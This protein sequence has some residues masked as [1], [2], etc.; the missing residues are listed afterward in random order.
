M[1]SLDLAAEPL[2]QLFDRLLAAYGPQHWW[3]ADS[4]FEVMLGAVL[5]QNTAW[6][7]VEKAMAALSE[8]GLLDLGALLQADSVEIAQCIR[9]AG[10]FNLKT[11]R[12]LALCR[13]LRDEGGEGALRQW[14][15]S[16]LR[17]ALLAVHGVGPETAD[18]ILLYAFRRPVFV[19]D[20]Y[21][22]RLFA[23]QGIC[24]G[25]EPY[26][27][28]R[29]ALERALG[30]DHVY[31]NEYHALIVCHAKE[32]CSKRP[33]CHVCCLQADCPQAIT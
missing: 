12:L 4:P 1:S 5:T 22:R 6:S 21:S 2:C 27:V 10:Y 8:A 24:Q 23:R 9:P 7:N 32:A 20:T 33:R 14:G 19:I 29:R 18:D 13:F 31:Y 15:T 16:R 25:D 26:E 28:L 3:P 17:Q 30:A 11:Q